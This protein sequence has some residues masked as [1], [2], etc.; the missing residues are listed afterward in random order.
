VESA[1]MRL[2]GG[3]LKRVLDAIKDLVADGN[4]D[5]SSTGFSLQAM[6]SS[7]VALVTLLLHADGFEHYRCDRN[8]SMGL[9]IQSMV[10][11]HPH[12]TAS[13]TRVPD[14][15]LALSVSKQVKML[16][17][18]GGDDTVTMKAD[19][20]AEKVNFMF[21]SPSAPLIVSLFACPLISPYP[22]RS[23][24]SSSLVLR[25]PGPHQRFR[26]QAHGH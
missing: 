1:L 23:I 26:A 13:P 2:Q 21:E 11:G 4:F 20:N 14:V 25:R 10:R 17:C 7:H 9:N 24:S 18:A 15:R 19:D 8:I 5:C 6:D 16:K 12:P 22:H 3:L